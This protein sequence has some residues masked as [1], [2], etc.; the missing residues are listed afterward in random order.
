MLAFG[1]ELE[2]IA[3]DKTIR[4][5]VTQVNGLVLEANFRLCDPCLVS[6]KPPR[7]ETARRVTQSDVARAAGVARATVSY[8][9]KS[10]P[11]IPA[12]TCRRIQEIARELGYAP[13]PMLS[14]LAFYRAR[15]RPHAFHGTLAWLVHGAQRYIRSWRGSQHY[16][17]YFEGAAKQ[18]L[19]HGYKLEEFMLNTTEM[20]PARASSILRARNISGILLCPLPKSEMEVD[21]KWDDFSV[22][23]FGHTL[24]HPRLHTV[25]SAHYHNVRYA[26]KK[27]RER[28]YRRIGLVTN[29]R[30]DERCHSSVSAGYLIE[31]H[32]GEGGPPIPPYLDPAVGDPHAP[33]HLQRF[34]HY[35]RSHRLDAVLTS[36]FRMLDR[37][38]LLKIAV[39]AELGIAGASLPEKD[40]KLAGIVEDSERIGAVAIDLLTAMIQ[41]GERGIPGMPI[42]SYVEGLWHDGLSLG[43]GP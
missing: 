2:C 34:R 27:L 40:E 23:A 1:R 30:T 33:D 18:A 12:A 28:G 35:I 42:H 20:S 38:R 15:Q 9:L 24:R 16:V 7:G 5:V 8:A 37:L 6:E 43:P 32:S 31:Q 11:K 21:F 19:C 3:A 29:R 14:S 10:H 26:M 25:A 13:D 36:E 4:G 22:V 39:P 41:R 17:S